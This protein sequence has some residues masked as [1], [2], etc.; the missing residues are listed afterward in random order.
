MQPNLLFSRSVLL[1]KHRTLAHKQLAIGG[2]A[3]EERERAR[4]LDRF[5]F[6]LT[7]H[8]PPLERAK[9][10][11]PNHRFVS[12][13][14]VQGPS[15]HQPRGSQNQMGFMKIKR[16]GQTQTPTSLLH[17]LRLAPF[18][19]PSLLASSLSFLNEI[20]NKARWRYQWAYLV[21]MIGISHHQACLE[22]CSR[23]DGWVLTSYC[24]IQTGRFHMILNHSC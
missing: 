6:L 1:Y 22:I 24:Q 21:D 17:L 13:N 16:W 19:L 9:S 11:Q 15:I 10:R 5:S 2:P 14:T 18:L 12:M 23:A 4:D 20:Y 8:L 7:S 3:R